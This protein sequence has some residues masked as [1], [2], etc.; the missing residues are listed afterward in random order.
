MYLYF[1]R[2]Y[3]SIWS[4][5]RIFQKFIYFY[6][7]LRVP[8]G[9][10]S[11]L[12]LNI[13]AL[14]VYELKKTLNMVIILRSRFRLQ[15]NVPVYPI[16]LCKYIHFVIKRSGANKIVSYYP[17]SDIIMIGLVQSCLPPWIVYIFVVIIILLCLNVCVNNSYFYELKQHNVY[18]FVVVQSLNI[19]NFGVVHMLFFISVSHNL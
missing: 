18:F 9:I 19:F 12:F 5:S 4:F 10:C 7:S 13:I 17:V 8:I 6:S 2:Q 11:Y 1:N 14:R 15:D 16:P 3:N